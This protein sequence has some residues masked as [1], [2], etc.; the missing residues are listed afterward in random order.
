MS[1]RLSLVVW[2]LV[3]LFFSFLSGCTPSEQSEPIELVY[4]DREGAM[5]QA[6]LVAFTKETGISVVYQPYET[7]EEVLEEMRQGE[8]FDVVVLE[9]EVIPAALRENLLS[10]LSLSN[11]PNFKNL[12]PSFRDLAFD[13]NNA[14]SIP[15][16]WGT[17]G[18][19]ARRNI[20]EQPVT[21]WADLWNPEFAGKII[22]WNSPRYMVGIALKSLGYSINSENAEELEAA[23][24]KLL[25]LKPH[26]KQIDRGTA[27]AAPYLISG[28]AVLAIGQVDE[29]MAVQKAGVEID[30]I[31]PAE[32]AILWSDNW[33]IPANSTHKEAAEQLINFFLRAEISAE[34]INTTYY[35]LP[36][37]AA[38][39]LIR[40][41]LR[42]NPA[43]VPDSSLLKNAEFLSGLSVQGE[44]LHNTVWMELQSAETSSH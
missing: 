3:C 43:V 41:D 9:S 2:M 13:P 16:R 23:K 18:L 4:R 5:P 36:N 35:W 26:M 6:V 17:T 14:H 1:R 38:V 42:D 24:Q 10:E 12:S 44:M 29:P 20:W 8:S 28:E 39:P 31:L 19:V 32:G 22:T 7:Q 40:A 25:E 27:V 15:Y 33:S 21:K 37:D 34:M 11:I 30:Y